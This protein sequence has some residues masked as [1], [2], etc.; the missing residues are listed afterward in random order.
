MVET[1]NIKEAAYLCKHK[2]NVVFILTEK[3]YSSLFSFWYWQ[4]KFKTLRSF[5]TI[6]FQAKKR[7]L[8]SLL[9][10]VEILTCRYYQVI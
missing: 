1:S 4:Y 2:E 7:F 3:N 6:R 5:K 9:K 10:S 8:Y